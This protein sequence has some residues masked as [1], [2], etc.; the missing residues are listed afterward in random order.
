MVPG[1][2]L[3]PGWASTPGARRIAAHDAVSLPTIVSAPL[4]FK[5]ARVMLDALG[6]PEVPGAWR[7]DHAVRIAPAADP[8]S[9]ACRVRTDDRIRPIWTVTAN[10]RGS[11]Q[12]DDVVIVGNHRDAWVYGG[13]DPSQRIGGADGARADAWTICSATGWRPKR[14]ILFAS[15]DAEEF[16]LTSSTEWGEQHQDWL[17]EQAV[18]YLNVDSAASGP[19]LSVAAVPALNQ[20]IDDVARTVKDPITRIPRRRDDAGSAVAR[21]RRACRRN[22]RTTSSTIGW[23]AGRTTRSS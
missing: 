22:A 14:T 7:G 12:P 16:A 4:S 19:N 21:S 9:C 18:A 3:T 8:Q 5:D 1:D 2:P 17:R 6:G 15:W 20:L 23:A 11:E 13:V 10:I